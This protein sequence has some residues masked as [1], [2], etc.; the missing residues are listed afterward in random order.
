MTVSFAISRRACLSLA[1]RP[2]WTPVS[3][4]LPPLPPACMPRGRP[5]KQ[6]RSERRLV[7]KA[8]A[9]SCRG[10][11]CTEREAQGLARRKPQTEVCFKGLCKACFRVRYPALAPVKLPRGAATP[12]TRKRLRGKAEASACRGPLCNVRA[13]E[14]LARRHAQPNVTFRWFCKAC[15]RV[16]F[17]ALA[18]V[19]LPSGAANPK[20]RRRL[21]GKA[22]ASACGGRGGGAMTALRRA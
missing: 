22:E 19:K 1:R 15:F 5:A 17:P 6:K 7:G 8:A 14:G 21:R 20:P 18:A 10:A 12:K 3:S 16:Q 13:A 2:C 4:C 11:L 9:S